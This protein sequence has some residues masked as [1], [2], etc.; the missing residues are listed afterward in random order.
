MVG[1]EINGCF[2]DSNQGEFS[3][4][5]MNVIQDKHGALVNK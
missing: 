3:N 2:I 5:A 4:P 1:F